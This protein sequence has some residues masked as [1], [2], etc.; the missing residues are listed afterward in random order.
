MAVQRHNGIGPTVV[1]GPFATEKVRTCRAR[2]HEYK[3]ARSIHRK[4]RP[5]VRCACGLETF[6]APLLV[7]RVRGITRDRVPAPYELTGPGVEGPHG[8]QFLQNR[9]VVADR[10]ANNHLAVQDGG[11]RGHEIVSPLI[12]FPELGA[13]A[14]QQIHR[15]VLTEIRASLARGRIEREQSAV[16]R[17]SVDACMAHRASWALFID[18]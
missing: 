15:S 13:H 11:G 6:R 5:R 8:T 10:G 14:I 2:G 16:E 12:A 1:A 9:T 17:R 7:H 18:P 3:V 4:R